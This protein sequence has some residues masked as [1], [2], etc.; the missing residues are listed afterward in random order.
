[1]E[2]VQSLPGPTA[3][4]R[5]EK[6]GRLTFKS[7]EK[8]LPKFGASKWFALYPNSQLAETTVTVLFFFLLKFSFLSSTWD[9]VP[10]SG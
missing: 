8:P 9:D 4:E 1:M 10:V 2:C 5:E 6:R 7:T 3:A